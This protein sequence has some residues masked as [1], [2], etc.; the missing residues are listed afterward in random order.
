MANKKIKKNWQMKKVLFI[1]TRNPYSGRYSGDVIRSL[2]IINL[3][4]KKLHVD[5]VCLSK[6]GFEDRGKNLVTFKLPNIF[7]KAIY[8][9]ISFLKFEPIQLG[10]F[11]SKEMKMHIENN[12][13]E[14]DYLFFYH[15]RSSQYFPKNFL[16]K[17][18]LE[19]GDLYSENY[20]QSF[21]YLN[22]F[23][24]L[25]YLYFF[26]SYFMKRLENKIFSNFDRIILF[27]KK[28]VNKINKKF[29]NRIFQIDESVEKVKSKYTFSKKNNKILF[30]GNL[31]YLP[32]L[33]ACRYFVF[34]VFPIIKKDLPGIKFVVIG[35]ISL[36]N[37]FLLSKPD[38]EI[39]GP[40]RNIH[41][42]IKKC[43]CGLAN[44]E[45]A[46]GVQGKVVTYMSFGL[47]VLCSKKVAQNFGANVI[48]Y[49]DSSEFR[50]K[51][52]DLKINRKLASKF[53]KKSIAFTKKLDWKKMSQKYFRLLKF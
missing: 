2:K 31:N 51:I 16:G 37:K 32:N 42:Y 19:M 7:L 36:I 34:K 28:E 45:I 52:I 4:K 27:S 53:S 12:C 15:V 3:L 33:L 17:K 44:L 41:P 21:K 13:Y 46:T 20:D 9:I 38:V 40:Q 14:Y 23:N 11:F 1:S 49:S 10:L 48:S 18:I 47:P 50:K 6:E 25:K 35:N 30:V 24:P 5:T 8:C 39:L 26:E 22:I 43:F 29:K